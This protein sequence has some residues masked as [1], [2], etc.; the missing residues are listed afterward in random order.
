M[1]HSQ[2]FE[3]VKRYYNFGYWDLKRVKDAVAKGW[4][5]AQEYTEITG[6]KYQ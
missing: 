1:T 6:K 4:I 3:S 2:K 5:T